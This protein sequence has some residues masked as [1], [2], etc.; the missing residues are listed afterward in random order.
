[1]TYPPQAV[2]TSELL[3]TVP[4]LSPGPEKYSPAGDLFPIDRTTFQT[5]PMADFTQHCFPSLYSVNDLEVMAS[6]VH[7]L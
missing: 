7:S 1:M 3:N 6:G 5:V 2:S 4:T